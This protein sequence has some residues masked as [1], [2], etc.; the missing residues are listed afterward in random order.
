[1]GSA[2][3]EVGRERD[4]DGTSWLSQ[5]KGFKVKARIMCENK[6]SFLLMSLSVEVG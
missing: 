5:G 2:C 6:D 3:L 1:M 4:P